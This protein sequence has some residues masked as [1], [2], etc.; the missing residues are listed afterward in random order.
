MSSIITSFFVNH[1]Y[2]YIYTHTH[3]LCV[4]QLSNE[5][6]KVNYISIQTRSYFHVDE[7]AR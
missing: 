7:N 3:T 4:C 6:A 1:I 5:R 2:I